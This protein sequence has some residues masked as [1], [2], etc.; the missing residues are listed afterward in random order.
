M[1]TLPL[2][3][4]RALRAVLLVAALALGGA[5]AAV[6]GT[7]DDAF[8]AETASAMDRMMA[9]MDVAPTGDVDRDF[10]A[11]MVPHHQGAIDMARAELRH[12][13]SERL[14]RIAQEIVVEQ[15]QEIVAMEAAR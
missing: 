15:Q 3:D 9:A 6:A 11:T 13:R 8:A 4:R 10:V 14:R 12:G 2:E 5:A 7:D 1:D